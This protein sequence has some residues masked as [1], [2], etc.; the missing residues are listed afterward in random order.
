MLLKSN[1]HKLQKI[2]AKLEFFTVLV[3]KI[4]KIFSVGVLKWKWMDFKK[5]KKIVFL[6]NCCIHDYFDMLTQKYNLCWS[7]VKRQT[8]GTSSDNEWQQITI[9]DNE[10]YNEWQR[11]VQR[12]TTSLQRV[13]TNGN[14]WQQ[15]KM[16]D[17]EWQK[18]VQRIKMGPHTPKNG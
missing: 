1:F 7:F 13:T 2:F 15:M 4:T 9:S 11:V 18:V 3:R 8:R 12:M 6:K 16:S 10:R 17:R 5:V 14:E